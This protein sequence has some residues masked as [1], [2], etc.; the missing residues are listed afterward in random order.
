MKQVIL[1]CDGSSLGN[2]GAGGYCGILTFQ[3]KHKTITG[4]EASTTNNRMELRAVIESLKALKEP[5]IVELYSD[6]LYVCDGISKW[7]SSWKKKGFRGIKNPDLWQ[8]YV[9]ISSTHTIHT[10]WVKAHAGNPQNELCDRLAKAAA[11]AFLEPSDEDSL[12]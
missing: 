10:H 2:P 1:Y 8:E 5:C 3:G 11:S 6:S 7:L 4:G 9:S 12:F